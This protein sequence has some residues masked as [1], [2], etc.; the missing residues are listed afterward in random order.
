[1]EPGAQRRISMTSPSVTTWSR[2]TR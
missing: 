2:P 1:V